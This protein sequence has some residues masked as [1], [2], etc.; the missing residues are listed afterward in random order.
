MLSEAS[1]G[2]HADRE[3]NC[4]VLASS[5]EGWKQMRPKFASS[6]QGS[7]DLMRPPPVHGPSI[8]GKFHLWYFAPLQEAAAR[9]EQQTRAQGWAS[10]L[11]GFTKLE[12]PPRPAYEPVFM[13]IQWV[14]DDVKAQDVAYTVWALAQLREMLR[15]SCRCLLDAI[16]REAQI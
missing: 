9:N 14:A 1:S 8:S 3:P 2:V 12:L 16:F 4:K 11:W 5:G 6:S 13:A 15:S 7:W 10:T